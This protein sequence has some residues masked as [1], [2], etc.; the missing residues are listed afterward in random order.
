MIN[1]A[2]VAVA[3]ELDAISPENWRWIVDTNFLGVVWGCRAALPVLRRAGGG[4]ILNVASAA[5][6]AAAP[7]MS[8]YNAT[9]AAVISL[10]E[11][12][13]A[14][15]GGTGIQISCAILGFFRS[16]LTEGLRAPPAERAV[17]RRLL[18]GASH[19]A[20]EAAQAI[21]AGGEERRLYI[22]WPREY[23]IFWRLKRLAPVLFLNEVS[24]L[25]GAELARCRDCKAGKAGG[26][27]EAPR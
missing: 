14:E 20:G 15:T 6:F 5:G 27:L 22:V 23:R 4:I 21:L 10:S 12:L 1:N 25:T 17:A 18:I 9:K 7:N 19:S 3:G 11:T 16:H 2:G 13:A 24:N 26:L 8:A